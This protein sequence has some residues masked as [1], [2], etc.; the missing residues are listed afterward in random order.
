MA[1]TGRKIEK[2]EPA[3]IINAREI[4]KIPKAIILF[5]VCPAAFL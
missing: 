5:I 3:P 4:I 2:P 1:G